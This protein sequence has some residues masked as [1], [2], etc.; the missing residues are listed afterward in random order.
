MMMVQQII[1]ALSGLGTAIEFFTQ[2][3]LS[4]ALFAIALKNERE[5]VYFISGLITLLI[6]LS[7]AANHSSISYGL[8]FL[9]VYE[10]MKAMEIVFEINL[11]S[12]GFSW[13]KGI[14]NKARGR[15]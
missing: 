15:D 13:V 10:F 4:I 5:S 8:L 7:L 1:D 3:A 14:Y 12:K 6:G 9:S 2:V 11:P